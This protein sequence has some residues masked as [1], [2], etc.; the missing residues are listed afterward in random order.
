MTLSDLG[1]ADLMIDQRRRWARGDRVRIE[2]YLAEVQGLWA[3]KEKILDLIYSEL[4]LREEQ[5]E[6]P[7]LEEYLARFPELVDGLREQFAVHQI[8]KDEEAIGR[9]TESD[10]GPTPG[11]AV[12]F[13][14]SGRLGR[15]EILEELGRGGMGLV[16]KARQEGLQ[17]VVAVKTV[18]AG[19]HA[20]TTLRQRYRAEAEAAARLTHANIVQVFEVGEHEGLPYLVLEYLPGGNLA[21][22]VGSPWPPAKAAALV[23]TLARAVA[24]AHQAGVVHR[25]LKPTNVLIGPDGQPKITDFGLAKLLDDDLGLTETGDLLGSPSYMAPEQ[26]RGERG[27][28]PAADVHALGAIFYELLTGRPPFQGTTRHETIAQVLTLEPVPP[29]RL[30]PR[31]ARDIETI[32]LKCL[33]KDPAKRYASAQGLADDLRRCLEGRAI[34]ARPTSL[35]ERAWKWARRRPTAAALDVVAA[36]ATAVVLGL[37]Y[38]SNRRIVAE[39]RVAE[40][41][42]EEALGVIDSMLVSVSEE[43]LSNVP[44]LTPLR[45]KPLDEATSRMK[46]LEKGGALRPRLRARL[47][48]IHVRLAHSFR[49]LDLAMAERQAAEAAKLLEG[50]DTGQSAEVRL[51]WAELGQIRTMLLRD[52]GSFHEAL[53]RIN[54]ALLSLDGGDPAAQE[55][56]DVRD[57]RAKCIFIRGWVH[58]DLKDLEAAIAD[59]LGAREYYRSEA[60]RSG[61]RYARQ[62]LAR[63]YHFLG[64]VS[65]DLDRTEDAER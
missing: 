20:S 15:L 32:A 38:E 52:R 44:K 8:F 3:D 64:W 13:L 54:R 37:A 22:L 50:L 30:Q 46:S 16:Y 45:K 39:R 28:G 21:G 29:R 10:R 62:E 41:R 57:L 47:A 26:A 25:D 27:V 48:E 63:A 61:S 4:L 31:L 6:R 2:D 7:D 33:E 24:G 1:P 55:T 14:E 49:G 56:Q 11:P 58:Q 60:E 17:R 42:L 34:L 59:F 65:Q 51:A 36:L 19:Q 12:H 23:E 43:D 9:S 40:G 5:G 53:H 35:W 18:L